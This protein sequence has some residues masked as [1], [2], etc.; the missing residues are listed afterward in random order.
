MMNGGLRSSL[1]WWFRIGVKVAL[2]ALPIPYS[3][4]KRFRVFEL[5]SM[6]DAQYA[7]NAFVEYATAA[8]ILDASSKAPKI[9]TDSERHSMS[10]KLAQGTLSLLRSLR[11]PSV[12]HELGLSILAPTRQRRYLPIWS[13][14][15]S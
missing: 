9:A 11:R 1:P 14:R 15:S 10:L 6:D 2:A 5:G 8:G 13:F 12:R 3:L 4:W 7:F